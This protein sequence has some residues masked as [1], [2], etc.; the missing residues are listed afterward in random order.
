MPLTTHPFHPATGE[1]LATHRDAY[2]RGDLSGKNTE[3][4]DAYLQAN[5]AYGDA[6]FQRYYT[7]KQQGHQVRP[8]GWLQHQ[9][10]LIRT[11][12][13]RFRKRAGSIAMVGLLIG[14]AVFAGTN[15]PTEN[16]PTDNLPTESPVALEAAGAPAEAE[17]AAA[18]FTTI[19]GRILDENG[20]PLVGATVL[21]KLN[22]R[23]V[24]TDANGNYTLLI[25]ANRASQLQYG[26][27]GYSEE[28]VAVRGR[29]STH[30]V[31]LLPRAKE[32]AKRRWWL[33]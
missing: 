11:E 33:F 24:S 28:E 6:A 14:G 25:P 3:L 30:N 17:V 19:R 12:P 2:L 10:E 31:T 15:L 21:D 20:R 16:L 32:Q 5:P 13:A 7:L 26:Y 22:K 9:F 27:G 8:V 18:A 29:A 1:L 23:G 4:V